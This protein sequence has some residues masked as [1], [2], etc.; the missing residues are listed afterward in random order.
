MGIICLFKN[1]D[2][3][4]VARGLPSAYI[5]FFKLRIGIKSPWREGLI[6]GLGQE[7]YKINLPH[8]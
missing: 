1:N 2:P 5:F 8:L 4:P 3:T 6:L 7:V